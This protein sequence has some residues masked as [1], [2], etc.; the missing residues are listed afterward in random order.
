MEITTDREGMK[1]IL[2]LIKPYALENP[3]EMC[4]TEAIW[5]YILIE[6]AKKVRKSMDEP[7]KRYK[8]KFR[9]YQFR[10]FKELLDRLDFLE[11]CQES[12]LKFAILQDFYQI[13]PDKTSF[14][15]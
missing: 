12:P 15:E 5:V 7:K 1:L 3:E 9:T 11:I 14:L 2:E 8:I 13:F 6:I 10:A 4:N